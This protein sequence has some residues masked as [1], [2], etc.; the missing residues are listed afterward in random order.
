MVLNETTR[1]LIQAKLD[2]KKEEFNKDKQAAAKLIQQSKAIE[3]TLQQFLK[4]GEY[5]TA[6]IYGLTELLKE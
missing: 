5:D 2:A 1:K 6:V 3:Q 4:K